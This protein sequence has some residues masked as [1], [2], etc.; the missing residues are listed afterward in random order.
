MNKRE[1]QNALESF[2]KFDHVVFRLSGEN[3]M[4]FLETLWLY[5]LFSSFKARE[6]S[7][8]FWTMDSHHLG[9]HEARAARNFD[10]VFVAHKNYLSLFPKESSSYLPCSFS[11]AP[12]EVVAEYLKSDSRDLNSSTQGDICAPFA[13]YP[14]QKRNLGYLE[15]LWATNDLGKRGFFGT[16]RG[17]MLPNEGLV[18]TILSHRVVFN[19]SLKDDLNMR[20]FEALALN[21]ILLTNRVTGHS[22]LQ[23]FYE[24]IVFLESDLSDFGEKLNLAIS[25]EPS[26][27]SSPFLAK[28]SIRS[29]TEELVGILLSKTQAEMKTWDLAFPRYTETSKVQEG[30]FEVFTPHTPELMM[31]RGGWPTVYHLRRVINQS[32][33]PIRSALQVFTMWVSSLGHYCL[34]FLARNIPLVKVM[35]E[36][37]SNRFRKSNS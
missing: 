27:I 23:E 7:V 6:Y 18:K 33:N 12:E 17:G 34:S 35:L 36:G 1:L 14:W 5:G 9:K 22:L 21:K 10:H 20:N 24:N 4:D 37:V 13:A 26:N 15:G 3:P 31:A 16:V 8:S 28:H 19:L 25:L 2:S 30:L 32:P 29:R 11:L